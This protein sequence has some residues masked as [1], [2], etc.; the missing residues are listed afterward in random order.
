LDELSVYDRALGA[1]EVQGIAEAG[2][3][4]KCGP[5]IPPEIVTQPM[6]LTV[7]A[8]QA[9]TFNV[10]ARGTPP[11]NYQWRFNGA[12]LPDATNRWLPPTAAQWSPCR[13]PGPF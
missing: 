13:R 1:A 5:T 11:L 4:G 2:P 9:A 6:S 3:V 12:P 8:G 10:V 7:Y